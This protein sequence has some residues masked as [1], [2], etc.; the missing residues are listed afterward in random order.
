MSMA[1]LRSISITFILV[2]VALPLGRAAIKQCIYCSWN[3]ASGSPDCYNGN[4]TTVGNDPCSG[5]DAYCLTQLTL[6]D[7]Y[8]TAIQR[9]CA[10]G[11]S[12]I[13]D[14][15]DVKPNSEKC[16]LV[17]NLYGSIETTTCY[18]SCDNSDNCNTAGPERLTLCDADCVYGQCDYITGS[19]V[20]QD[21]YSG[22]TCSTTQKTPLVFR[23]CLQCDD[24]TK[25]C[26]N[27][28]S[29]TECPR[30]DQ[31][32]CAVTR[33]ITYDD[34]EEQ[35]RNVIT[36][37]CT[38][39]YVA[40]DECFISSREGDLPGVEYTCI[41]TC[42]SD[43]CN[44]R[45]LD[46]TDLSRPLFCVV[47]SSQDTS[48]CDTSTT[49]QPCPSSATHCQSIVTY[50]KSD[51]MDRANTVDPDYMLINVERSCATS[52][53]TTQC[54]SSSVGSFGLEKVTCQESCQ[55]DICNTGWPAR[56]KCSQ[57][58]CAS[59][60]SS[61]PCK[62]SP[63]VATSCDYPYHEFCTV[64]D[65]NHAGSD[66]TSSVDGYPRSIIRGCSY[67]GIG[68]DCSSEGQLESCNKTCSVDGCNLG[69]SAPLQTSLS[70]ILLMVV[71]LFFFVCNY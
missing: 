67:K 68:N 39:D 11:S 2:S 1:G 31:K 17:S 59:C 34:D 41:S 3:T 60:F 21:G 50:Y 66:R 45:T 65:N 10:S 28:K 48:G 37:S 52:P 44:T 58:D 53:V 61:H 32:Y 33:T 16:V 69:N 4:A 7:G 40:A 22:K 24:E 9:S 15:T 62:T 13:D 30:A 56:P 54:T 46:E 36:R 51:K 12:D 27:T 42:D 70:N 23:R 19:C 71:S 25:S 35:K 6:Q 14:S 26:V 57:C 29:P 38:T 64:Q 49:V 5:S 20:C 8:I 43:G 63:P 18:I 55:G 47:C